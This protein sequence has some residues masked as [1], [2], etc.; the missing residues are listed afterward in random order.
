MPPISFPHW[1]SDGLCSPGG[2][3][4][5]LRRLNFIHVGT[6]RKKNDQSSV[7]DLIG[8]GGSPSYSL[9]TDFKDLP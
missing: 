3:L 2:E 4:T 8:G 7:G 9:F 6:S 5:I 1:K